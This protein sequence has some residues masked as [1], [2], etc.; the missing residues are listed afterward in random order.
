MSGPDGAAAVRPLPGHVIPLG[1]AWATNTVNMVIF[2]H[3]GIVTSG[4]FQFTAFY[5]SE[6]VISVVRRDLVS[7]PLCRGEIAGRYKLDDAH[8]SI[9]LGVDREG[10]IHICYDHHASALRYRRSTSPLNVETWTDEMP[11]NSRHER[12]VTYPTFIMTPEP[13]PLL[14]LYRNGRHDKGASVLKRYD[15]CHQAWHDVASAVTSGARQRPWTSNAYWNHPAVDDEGCIHLALVWRTQAPESDGRINNIGID[16]ACSPDD[17]E[18]W[19]SSRGYPLRLPITQVNSETVL[20]V[21]HGTNLINQSGMAVTRRGHPHIVFYA[22]DLDGVPQYQHLW[23]DGR[24]WRHSILSRRIEPFV[25]SG[26]GTLRLPISRPEIVVDSED[27][28]YVIYRGDL[29]RDRLVAQ[30]LLPPDYEADPADLRVL[31]DET[32]GF[33]EPVL[34]RARWRRDGILSMLI[35]RCNQPAHD[36][37]AEASSEPIRIVDWDLVEDW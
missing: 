15:E 2:R 1:E 8:N 35:Q 6:A 26:S 24:R 21:P 16:Y 14:M 27:K 37:S 17:G 3:H 12:R 23:F 30:R 34:D 10:Y 25:L 33:A 19:R 31:W 22:D 36:A 18:S 4:R 20:P 9:S 32:L 28:V 29:T 11:M 5:E 13:G 7:G